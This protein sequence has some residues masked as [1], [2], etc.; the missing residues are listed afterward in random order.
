MFGACVYNIGYVGAA[1]C[2]GGFGVRPMVQAMYEVRQTA[3]G[4]MTA[5][6][7]ALGGHGVVGVSLTFGEFAFGGLELQA[8]GTAVRGAAAPAPPHP[9]SSIYPARTSLSI[10]PGLRQA[11]PRGLGASWPG[12]GDLGRGQAR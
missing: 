6:C 9:F 3:I 12:G 2:A 7:A 5:E 1:G 8:I 4:R 10:R 11:H